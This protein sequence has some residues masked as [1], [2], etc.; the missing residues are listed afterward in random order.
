SHPLAEHSWLIDGK[1]QKS[2]QVFFIPQITKTY[3][4]VYICFIH[5]SVT[6]GRNLVIKR[7]IVPDHSLQSALSLDVTGSMELPEPYITSKNFNPMENKNVVALTCEPKTQGYTYVGRVNCQSLPV[8]PRLKKPGKN[9]ILIL[10]SV[11]R[12]DTGPYECEIRGRVGSICS[13]PVTLDVLF[14]P[15]VPSIF[16]SLTDYQSGENLYLSCFTD[17]NPPA[18]YTW[19]MHGKFLQSRQELF[20]L[21]TTTKHTRIYGC[22][23]HN[24]TTGRERSIFKMIRVS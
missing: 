6:G 7:V 14:G 15:D 11:T 10:T 23:A 21:Q 12:N 20:I 24:S 9:R 13:D 1:F 19:S 22:S 18:K 16:P 17:S 5:S 4:G 3:R 2:A 8:S